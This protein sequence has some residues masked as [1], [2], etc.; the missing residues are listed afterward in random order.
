MAPR[1]E[2][3]ISSA[4]ARR[5]RHHRLSSIPASPPGPGETERAHLGCNPPLSIVWPCPLA[6]SAY[7]ALGQHIELGD[8]PC[9]TCGQRLA[10]WGGYWRWVRGPST[11]LVW[12]R[13]GRCTSCRRSHALLPDFLLEHRLD[14][15]EV[16][17][18]SLA[19][20]VMGVSLRNVAEQLAVPVTTAREWQRRFQ[21]R[22]STLAATFVAFAVQLDP[23][24]V[25][26]TTSGEA[27]ALEALGAAW[28]ALALLI[29]LGRSGGSGA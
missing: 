9:P 12:I 14:E 27:A 4:S 16:I 11:E 18:R 17:G 2:A 10:G 13:R 23:A 25:L 1:V 8:Q 6:V 21:V 29:A 15:V 24:A 3:L 20:H 28:H 19:L 22:A 26:L 5:V 7:L